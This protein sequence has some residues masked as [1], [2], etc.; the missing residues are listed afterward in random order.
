[1]CTR[2]GVDSSSHFLLKHG[3]TDKQTDAIKSSIHTGGYASM[4]NY[5]ETQQQTLADC[6]FT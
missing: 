1:M 5:R 2:F 6:G 4:D 3:Q